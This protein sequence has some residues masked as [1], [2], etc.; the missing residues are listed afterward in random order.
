[1]PEFSQ[2]ISIQL[3][4]LKTERHHLENYKAALNLL[5]SFADD[6][7]VWLRQRHVNE[8]DANESSALPCDILKH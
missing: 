4:C 3:Q 2:H 5:I 1:M 6:R 8:E 7:A